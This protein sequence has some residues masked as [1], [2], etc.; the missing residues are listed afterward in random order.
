MDGTSC[1]S[2]RSAVPPLLP[3]PNEHLQ[4]DGGVALV[5]RPKRGSSRSRG[6]P[7]RAD[8][9]AT[10]RVP[11]RHLYGPAVLVMNLTLEPPAARDLLSA[12]SSV[13]ACETALVAWGVGSCAT[14][15]PTCPKSE[16]WKKAL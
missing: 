2:G 4:P 15:S 11:R 8:I 10:V 12:K 16:S 1:R 3:V 6:P 13:E 9:V 7:G 5:A 14:A